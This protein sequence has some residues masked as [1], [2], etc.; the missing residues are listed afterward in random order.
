MEVRL[1]PHEAIL[2]TQVALTRYASA[3]NNKQ[4]KGLHQQNPW[5]R[6]CMDVEGAGSEYAVAK[7]LRLPWSGNT[8][9]GPDILPNIDVKSTKHENGRLLISPD[10]EDDWKFVL[11]TGAM[12]TYHVIGWM[13]GRDGKKEQYLTTLSHNRPPVYAVPQDKLK[14][15]I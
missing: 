6:I 11:V 7:L 9:K 5:E 14:R 3:M 1:E 12:P 13:M 10:A 4:M 2:V 8:S 15:F